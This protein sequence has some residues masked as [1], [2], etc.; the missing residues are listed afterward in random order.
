MWEVLLRI[1][2]LI[3]DWR[4]K[5]QK[6]KD[7]IR[8]LKLWFSNKSN[9]NVSSGRLDQKIEQELG[10]YRLGKLVKPLKAIKVCSLFKAKNYWCF[11]HF[12]NNYNEVDIKNM[13]ADVKKGL[14]DNE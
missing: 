8:F 2:K 7:L 3:F 4:E 9:F 6:H 10:D 14:Y 13:V 1:L 12:S 5:H 11:T